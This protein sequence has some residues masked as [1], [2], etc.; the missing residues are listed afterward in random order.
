M[1]R[2]EGVEFLCRGH[3]LYFVVRATEGVTDRHDL[4]SGRDFLRDKFRRK[5]PFKL[6]KLLILF[7]VVV[8]WDY[9][10]YASDR[11][12][13]HVSAFYGV[14]TKQPLRQVE[15][16]DSGSATLV[17][18]EYSPRVGLAIQ[19]FDSD[20]VRFKDGKVGIFD[21]LFYFFFPFFF[22]GFLR[23][24]TTGSVLG[25]LFCLPI[26]PPNKKAEQ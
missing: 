5:E 16:R 24:V 11:L 2:H 22:F 23:P 3:E 17:P 7:A 21:V 6:D 25:L 26:A 10:R 15:H 12:V 9:L 18:F 19:I 13:E 14:D 20:R 1:D 4:G 8:L